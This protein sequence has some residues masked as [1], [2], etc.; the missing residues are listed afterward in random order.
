[1]ADEKDSSAELQ[2]IA[3]KCGIPSGQLQ[4]V[5][6]TVRWNP[7]EGMAYDQAECVINELKASGVPMKHGYVIG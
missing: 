2:A 1:M 6:G 4:F 3:R 5:E 7:P